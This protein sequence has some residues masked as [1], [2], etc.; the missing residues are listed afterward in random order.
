MS[1]EQRAGRRLTK[2]LFR[3]READG[4]SQIETP[5]AFDLG[6]DRYQL[7]MRLRTRQRKIRRSEHSN[8]R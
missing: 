6:D 1:D 2:V 3:V 4:S 7:D 8:E 5:W